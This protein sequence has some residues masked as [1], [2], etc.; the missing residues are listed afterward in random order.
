MLAGIG[1]RLLHDAIGGEPDP[2][3]KRARVALDVQSDVETGS[4]RL[5]EQRLELTDTRLRAHHE[6]VSGRAQDSKQP[7]I[8]PSE[9]LAAEDGWLGHDQVG[10]SPTRTIAKRSFDATTFPGTAATCSRATM[11][12]QQPSS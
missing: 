6:L 11:K 8:S 4:S 5:H 10:S 9:S 7:P 1:Q 2:G 3:R 12:R